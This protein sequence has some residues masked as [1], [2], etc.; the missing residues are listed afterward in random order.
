[1]GH[2]CTYQVTTTT[3]II[4]VIPVI[5]GQL[6]P[7]RIDQK[8]SEQFTWTAHQETVQKTAILGM[9]HILQKVL[10]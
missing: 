1:M 5:K 9:A 4:I 3:T 6:E 2:L 10:M 7:I 8:M